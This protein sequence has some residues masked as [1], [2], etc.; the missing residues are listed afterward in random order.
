LGEKKLA[1]SVR[2]KVARIALAHPRISVS[3]QA[4][5]GGISRSS[6]SY[7][8]VQTEEDGVITRL[9]DELYPEARCY[10]S[11]KS[12]AALAR[13]GYVVGLE[14]VPK[15]RRSIGLEAIYPK[16]KLSQRHPEH[17]V[18]PSLVRGMTIC[19]PHQVWATEIP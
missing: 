19:R 3:R 12:K 7:T 1:C 11:R 15:L 5:L 10:G 17:R 9:I 8:P 2:E 13:R 6:I 16:P 18:D 4:E 14:R